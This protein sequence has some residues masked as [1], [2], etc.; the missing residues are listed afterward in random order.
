MNTCTTATTTIPTDNN[1]KFILRLTTTSFILYYKL[2]YIQ[3]QNSGGG[4][5]CVHLATIIKPVVWLA[6]A[7]P[8]VVGQV[9]LIYEESLT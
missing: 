5:G 4:G 8:L 3:L 7:A 9:V 6:A 2:P 1:D